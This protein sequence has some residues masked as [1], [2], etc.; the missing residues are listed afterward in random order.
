[1]AVGKKKPTKKKKTGLSSNAGETRQGRASLSRLVAKTQNPK[2]KK[3]K[4]ETPK[5]KEVRK[6]NNKQ[7]R[8]AIRK[9]GKGQRG[10]AKGKARNYLH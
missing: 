1:M 10:D 7:R 4:N 8:K 5:Q 2:T 9:A 6:S 3:K